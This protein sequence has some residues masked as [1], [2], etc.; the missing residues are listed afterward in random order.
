MSGLKIQSRHG[1]NCSESWA[2][3][4]TSCVSRASGFDIPTSS[5]LEISCALSVQAPADDALVFASFVVAVVQVSDG[6]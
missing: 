5:G 6:A 4:V 2:G 3:G 1:C